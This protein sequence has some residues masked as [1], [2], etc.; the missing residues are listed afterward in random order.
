ME[1]ALRYSIIIRLKFVLFW[2][3]CV[4]SLKRSTCISALEKPELNDCENE[5][6]DKLFNECSAHAQI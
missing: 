2:R 6:G 5:G 1:S 3:V 4:S